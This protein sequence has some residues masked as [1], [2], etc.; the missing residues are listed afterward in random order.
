MGSTVRYRLETFL[1]RKITLTVS[2]LLV[3]ISVAFLFFL[4][5]FPLTDELRAIFERIDFVVLIFLAAEFCLR[6]AAF[7]KSY[8]LRDFGWIDLLAI[9]P[10]LT[11][12]VALM[13]ELRALRIARLIRLVRVIRVVRV[14]RSLDEGDTPHLQMKVRFF[15]AVSSAAMLFLL[16]TAVAIVA[17]VDRSVGD[18][19]GADITRLLDQIELVIMTSAVLAALGITATA[20]HFL[21]TLVTDRVVAVNRYLDSIMTGGNKLPLR[22]DDLGDEITELQEKVGRV[23]S[24]FVL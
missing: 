23:S 11:P 21:K 5:L 18:I 8:F 9:I 10:I 14:L 1:S 24:V 22:S 20:N 16:A 17:L 19:P 12:L 15:L 4:R 6:L 13:G 2:N 3:V 7:G